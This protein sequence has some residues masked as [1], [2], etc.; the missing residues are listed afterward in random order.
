MKLT[1][2]VLQVL[3][4]ICGSATKEK[5]VP[6]HEP[7]FRNTNCEY[8]R[9]YRYWLGTVGKLVNRFE[10]ELC[11]YTGAKYAVILVKGTVALRLALH[12]VGVRASDEVLVSPLA[13]WQLQMQL[14]MWGDTSF[15]R[16]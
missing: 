4:N 14:F 11:T 9:V 1:S 2:E 16:Y 3:K 12:E 5:P 15:C 8:T 10:E 6:L 13:S 7:Y